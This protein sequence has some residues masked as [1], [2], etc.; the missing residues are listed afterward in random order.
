VQSFKT[1]LGRGSDADHALRVHFDLE[2][3]RTGLD[4]LPEGDGIAEANQPFFCA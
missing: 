1:V 3:R 4:L 2:L